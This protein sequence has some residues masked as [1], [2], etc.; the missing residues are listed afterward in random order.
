MVRRLAGVHSEY[1]AR[2]LR[3][4]PWVSKRQLALNNG[5]PNIVKRLDFRH[6]VAVQNVPLTYDHL[7]L[8]VVFSRLAKLHAHVASIDDLLENG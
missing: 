3:C 1:Q 6:L 4:R 5:I 8:W 2:S 7:E